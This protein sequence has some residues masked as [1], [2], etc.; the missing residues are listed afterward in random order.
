MKNTQKV[1]LVLMLASTVAA[2]SAA[3]HTSPQSKSKHAACEIHTTEMFTWDIPANELNPFGPTDLPRK[4]VSFDVTCN[5]PTLFTL[6]ITDLAA[7]SVPES[8]AGEKYFFGLGLFDHKPVGA[9]GLQ[10]LDLAADGHTHNVV[11]ARREGDSWV[12]QESNLH[13]GS[14][15]RFTNGSG[16]PD[17]NHQQITHLTGKLVAT[18]LTVDRRELPAS[19]TIPFRGHMTFVIGQP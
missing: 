9:Y 13:T 6:K 10:L 11:M 17:W 12:P 19:G 18:G 3:E 5:E 14:T 7:D 8:F 2:T 4:E 1:W 15:I 16:I